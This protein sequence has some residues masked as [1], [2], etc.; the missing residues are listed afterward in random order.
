[1]KWVKSAFKKIDE[2]FAVDNSDDRHYLVEESISL[3]K[4]R[5]R[6]GKLSKKDERRL[7]EVNKKL[8][9]GKGDD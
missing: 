4:K 3:E 8:D 1:M 9:E 7:A 5:N 6:I 2:F